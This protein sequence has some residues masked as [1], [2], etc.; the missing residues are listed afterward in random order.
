MDEASVRRL[1]ITDPFSRPEVVRQMIPGRCGH[2]LD[3]GCGPNIRQ[4]PYADL[5][6]RITAVDWNLQEPQSSPSNVCGIRG[7]FLEIPLEPGSFDVVLLCDVFEHVQ[8]EKEKEFCERI[9]SLIRPG[10][11]LIVTLPHRGRFA[12]LDPYQVKPTV[13]RWFYRVG[14]YRKVHNGSCDVRK[15]HKHYRRE[16]IEEHFNSL[17]TAEIVY[18]SYL[19]YPLS[20][21]IESARRRFRSIPGDSLL[22]R[23]AVREAEHDYG[24]ASYNFATRMV[25]GEGSEVHA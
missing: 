8:L 2:L 16:E 14:V 6:D 13:H 20:I 5:A 10:G 7:N 19:Y 15:G 22:R 25:K 12:W 18:W 17:R 21:W 4:Y 1:K 24:R 23:K 9:V 3:V 11:S